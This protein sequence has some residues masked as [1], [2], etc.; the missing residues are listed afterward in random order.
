M[1]GK[2]SNVIAKAAIP[3][4]ICLVICIALITLFPQ[5][6]TI[7]PDLFMGKEQ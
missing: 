4:F 1:T 2:D 7:V 6:V 3:F 5:I